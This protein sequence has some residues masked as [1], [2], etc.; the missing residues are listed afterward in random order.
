MLAS[1]GGKGTCTPG[2]ESGKT[3]TALAAPTLSQR[4]YINKQF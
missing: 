4:E 3:V 2:D 1:G